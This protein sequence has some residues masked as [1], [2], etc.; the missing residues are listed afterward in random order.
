[1]AHKG[2]STFIIQRASAVVI[3][4][5][6]VWFL[7]GVVGHLNADYE[8]ARAWLAQPINGLLIGLFIAVAAMHM[9]VGMAE[10]IIDYIH[11]GLKSV[12]LAIN[13]IAALGLALA[14]VWSVFKV[15]FAG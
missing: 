7:V 13:W 10:I 6:A 9:R 4:P 11:G 1:M 8:T 14:A 12:L 5:L 2:T 3:L 15:S